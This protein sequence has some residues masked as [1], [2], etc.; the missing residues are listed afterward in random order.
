MQQIGDVKYVFCG[1][2]P[3]KVNLPLQGTVHH[4]EYAE[5]R[6]QQPTQAPA[7]SQ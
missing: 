7:P 5:V 6:R 4:P 2:L 3:D 1:Q